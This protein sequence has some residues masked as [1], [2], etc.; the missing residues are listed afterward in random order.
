M[1]IREIL[2]TRKP[3]FSFEFFPPK[4]PTGWD[5][6]YKT[7]QDLIPLE[8]AYVSVTY[9]A[10]GTIRENTHEL[11]TRIQR[12]TGLTVVAHLTCVGATKEEIRRVLSR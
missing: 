6:L 10:G 12:E 11:V 5:N 2:E 8:P 3:S 1:L 4:K 7:I 9:G